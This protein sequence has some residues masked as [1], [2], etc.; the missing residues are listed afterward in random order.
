MFARSA[1]VFRQFARTMTTA[2]ARRA[3]TAAASMRPQLAF[4]A[5]AMALGGFLA[6]SSVSPVHAEA[7]KKPAAK[8]AASSV[9]GVEGGVERTFIALKPDGT[10]RRLLGAVIQRFEQK[11]YKLVGIKAVVPTKELAEEHYADLSSRPFFAGLVSYMTSGAAPVIAMVWEGKNVI[12]TGRQ[13]IGA[14]NPAD[15]GPGTIRGDFCITVGRNIIHGSDSF[16]AA[17]KEIAAWF[18]KEETFSWDYSD[19]E[20]V[21]ADN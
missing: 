6:V 21:A 18:K 5:G 20:W 9:A 11:G 1:P 2:T 8:A 14:T 4:A 19:A 15:A 7:K 3:P 12:K 10:Q 16:G 13:I 17:E